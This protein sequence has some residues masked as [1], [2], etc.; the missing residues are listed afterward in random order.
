MKQIFSLILVCMMTFSL[1]GCSAGESSAA[2]NSVVSESSAAAENGT[3]AGNG[4]A[5]ETSELPAGSGDVYK[6]QE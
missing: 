2:E 4:L 1:A 6:R 3:V 5:A